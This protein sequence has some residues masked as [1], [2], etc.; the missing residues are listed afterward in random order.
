[1]IDLLTRCQNGHAFDNRRFAACPYCEKE[2]AERKRTLTAD[3]SVEIPINYEAERPVCGWI[4]CIEGPSRGRDYR[5]RAGKNFI[6]R[7]DEMDIQ[8]LGDNKISHRNHAIVAYDPKKRKTTLLPG[9]S[10]GIA[11][12][13]EEPVYTPVPLEENDIIEIG[14]SKFR[15]VPFCGDHFGWGDA[16]KNKEEDKD[17][18]NT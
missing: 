9:D 7:S 6:G 8:I 12:W 3:E 16:G 2:K 4:V 10:N 14:E 11:Y 1:V 5:I 13:Q 15:F 17:T 18:E